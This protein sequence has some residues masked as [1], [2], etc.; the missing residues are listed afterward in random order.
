V[1]LEI[2]RELH[3]RVIRDG[4]LGGKPTNPA[5]S[6]LYLPEDS[7]DRSRV[8]PMMLESV[9]GCAR[10][11][12]IRAAS[13]SW[14]GVSKPLFGRARTGLRTEQ[15]GRCIARVCHGGSIGRRRECHGRNV[16]CHVY[17]VDRQ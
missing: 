9:F 10:L 8:A 1:A 13:S 7:P 16:V 4:S 11:Q 3:D 12:V 6:S 2:A 17:T 15:G 5:S 14:E